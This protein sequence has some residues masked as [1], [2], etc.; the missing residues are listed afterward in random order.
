MDVEIVEFKKNPLGTKIGRVIVK[1]HDIF[2]KC[3]LMFYNKTKSIWIKMPE[4]WITEE[5]KVRFCYWDDKE[6]SDDFQKTVLNKL[7]DKYDLDQAKVEEIFSQ[8]RSHKPKKKKT[9]IEK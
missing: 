9:E 1:Y 3:E 2:L 6:L 5:K 8:S 4:Q 7:F